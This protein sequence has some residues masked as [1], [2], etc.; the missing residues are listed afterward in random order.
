MILIVTNAHDLTTD[1]IVLELQRR[2]TPYFRLNSENLPQARLTL[3]LRSDTDWTFELDGRQVTGEAVTAAY[4]RRPGAP[5][6]DPGVINDGERSYCASEWAAVLK[7]LYLR[8][9]PLWLNSPEAIGL[10]EDKPRQ[11]VLAMAL[12]FETPEAIVTNDATRLAAFVEAAPS[13]AKPLREALLE[14]EAERVIFTS[15]VDRATARDARAIA[16]AP[17]ILQREIPKATD[18]RV[19]VVGDRVFSAAIHSQADE[20]SAVDWRRGDSVNLRH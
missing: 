17:F 5:E 8:L 16:A 1:Y 19:T 10:A 2:G 9:G 20:D 12:G 13:I 18:V 11:L 15:R 6:I 4:F 3:G 7:S 14:G